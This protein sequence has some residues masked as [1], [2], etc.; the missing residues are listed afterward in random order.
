M[1]KKSSAAANLANWVINIIRYNDIFVEV[2]PLKKE[3]EESK[4]LADLKAEELREVQEQVAEIVAKVNALKAD[5]AAA[6][7]KKQA[8]VDQATALQ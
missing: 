6:E 4:A 8:V 2:V 3:A 1:M 5:L 7:A